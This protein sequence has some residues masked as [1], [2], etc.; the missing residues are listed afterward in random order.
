MDI[1]TPGNETVNGTAFALSSDG[2]DHVVDITDMLA[3]NGILNA[4]KYNDDLFLYVTLYHVQA[5]ICP[6][7]N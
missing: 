6:A 7:G 2:P 3:D 1:V 4:T 5:A